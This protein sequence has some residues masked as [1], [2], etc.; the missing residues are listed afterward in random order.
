MQLSDRS[1]FCRDVL[2]EYTVR[3]REIAN[4][5]LKNL[6]KLVDL[7]EDYFVNMLDEKAMTHARFNYYP[8]CPKPDHVFGLKP[9][10]DA[11]VITIV[12]IDDNVSGL[13][14]QDNGVWYNVPIVPNALLVNIGDAMEVHVCT[15]LQTSVDLSVRSCLV[16]S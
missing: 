4:L 14:A 2:C 15:K 16:D 6:A 7:H 3:C 9:H 12:F 5:V 1:D 10:S 13:Q 11:S 8:H